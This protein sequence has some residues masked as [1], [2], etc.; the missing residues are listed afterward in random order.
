MSSS[1]KRRVK[2]SDK[3]SVI[4]FNPAR[5][6]LCVIKLDINLEMKP[7][8]QVDSDAIEANAI[9]SPTSQRPIVCELSGEARA[10]LDILLSL[11]EPCHRN[12]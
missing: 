5:I 1:E 3:L 4:F 7:D 12:P 10:K 6:T 9:S 2:E 11:I 8:E